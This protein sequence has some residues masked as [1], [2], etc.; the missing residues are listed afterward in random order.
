MGHAKARS[1]SGVVIFSTWIGMRGEGIEAYVLDDGELHVQPVYTTCH[2]LH[3]RND[4]V[5]LLLAFERP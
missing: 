4:D 5:A 1:R 2:S 3:D